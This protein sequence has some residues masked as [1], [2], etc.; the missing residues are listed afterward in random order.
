[1]VSA[2]A[3]A[4]EIGAHPG[5]EATEP[6]VERIGGIDAL[7][8]DVAPIQGALTCEE[9][10][11]G[12]EYGDGI[13]VLTATRRTN[14]GAPIVAVVEPGKRMRVYLLD[15][16]EGAAARTLAVMIVAREADFDVAIEAA[17]PILD[18]FEFHGVQQ[19]T[20]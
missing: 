10:S 5:L 19:Q 12:D 3:L 14:L 18:S 6:V 16:P 17:M 1:M 2:E 11:E 7:R 13:P 8:L 15:L 4:N 20:D 9:S